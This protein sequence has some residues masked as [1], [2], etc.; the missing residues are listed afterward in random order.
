M[1]T[2]DIVKLMT[3]CHVEN[4]DGTP[5]GG[6]LGDEGPLEGL[7]LGVDDGEEPLGDGLLLGV[8]DGEEPLGD[9]PL[10]GLLLGVDDGE[11]TTGDE[12]LLLGGELLGTECK[13][14]VGL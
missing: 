8:D 9:G 3:S 10:E 4:F 14:A 12:G 11:E 5:D 13:L 7:L 6:P 2:K 1:N